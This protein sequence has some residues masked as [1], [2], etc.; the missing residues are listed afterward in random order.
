MS[1]E[2]SPLAHL[3]LEDAADAVLKNLE[4]TDSENIVLVGHSMAGHVISRVAEREPDRIRRLIYLAAFMPVDR[5]SFV[6]YLSLPEAQTKSGAE[7]NLGD[8]NLL[9]ASRIDPRSLEPEYL[10]KLHQEF[11]GDVDRATFHAFANSLTPDQPLG[12]FTDSPKITKARWGRVPRTFILTT[13]DGALAPA[14]QERFI[15]EAD[16]LTPDNQTR[17]V[18]IDSSHSPFASQPEKLAKALLAQKE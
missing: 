3:S 16:L 5:P 17:V 1:K 8:P 18:R 6:N 2:R 12:Y 10:E 9:G 14:L 11:Y 7:I 4:T 15:R 13:R